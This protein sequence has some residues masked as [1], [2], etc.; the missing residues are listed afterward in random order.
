MGHDA[1]ANL[2]HLRDEEQEHRERHETERWID[3]KANTREGGD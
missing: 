2:D 3:R 1:G